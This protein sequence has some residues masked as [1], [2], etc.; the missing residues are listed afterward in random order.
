MVEKLYVDANTLMLDCFKLARSVYDSGYHPTLLIGLWRGGTSPTLAVHE[1]LTFKGLNSHPTFV[2]IA[3]Y[4]RV[5]KRGPMEVEGFE[6][7]IPLIK[8]HDK[9][10]IVDDVFDTGSTVKVLIEAIKK[11]FKGKTP[12]IRVA[13]VFYKPNNNETDIVPDYYVKTT[14]AWIVFPHELQDLTREEL[15]EKGDELYRILF[16]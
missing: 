6:Q 13:T 4:R 5:G 16:E 3:S 8:I 11:V 12:E 7:I 1:F 10:L 2:R 9:L 15:K 14:D